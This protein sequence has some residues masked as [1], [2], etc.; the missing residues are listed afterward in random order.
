MQEEKQY[1]IYGGSSPL[2]KQG[3]EHKK[4]RVKRIHKREAIVGWREVRK[5]ET[6]ERRLEQTGQVRWWGEE[7]DEWLDLILRVHN[8][9][10]FYT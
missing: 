4:I 2:N 7:E 9:D 10:V 8:R 6:A 5:Q 1:I 3:L